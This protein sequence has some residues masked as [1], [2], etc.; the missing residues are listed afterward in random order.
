MHHDQTVPLPSIRFAHGISPRL[1]DPSP[2]PFRRHGPS[3][4]RSNSHPVA[5]RTGSHGEWLVKEGV[6]SLCTW[7]FSAVM[8]SKSEPLSATRPFAE[9]VKLTWGMVS[10]GKGQFALRMAFLRGYG[11]QVRAPFGDTALRRAG[12]TH[13]RSPVAPAAP[14]SRFRRWMLRRTGPHFNTAISAKWLSGPSTW[15]RRS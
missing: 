4:S 8:G 12:Q 1:W 7:H 15:I 10:Q 11:I 9:P 14:I 2:S 3:P 6:N 13:I 5:G